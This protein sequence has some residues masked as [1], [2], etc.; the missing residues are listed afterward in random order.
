MLDGMIERGAPKLDGRYVVFIQCNAM[1]ARDWVEPVVMTW[2]A[3]KWH[4]EFLKRKIIGWLGPLPVLK[5]DAIEEKR[6]EE[7]QFPDDVPPAATEY[8]L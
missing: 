2:S 3:G 4:T 7:T 8:D 5:V 6:G 1:A